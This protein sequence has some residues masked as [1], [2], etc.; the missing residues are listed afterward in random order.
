MMSYF[1]GKKVRITL[2]DQQANTH[3]GVVVEQDG[4]DRVMIDCETCGN[5]VGDAEVPKLHEVTDIK[6][7]QRLGLGI[8]TKPIT[9]D[10]CAGYDDFG[11][12]AVS[13][14]DGN[15]ITST[16]VANLLG[17][18]CRICLRGWE[19]TGPGLRDQFEWGFID[20]YV[21]ES[22]YTRYA[23]LEERSAV[24]LSLI[25]ARYR[26]RG[27]VEIENGYW[28]KVYESSKKPW[29]R[30]RLMDF[31]VEMT[32]GRRKRVWEI[33]VKPTNKGRLV[34][35]EKLRKLLENEDVTKGFSEERVYVHAWSDLKLVEYLKHIASCMRSEV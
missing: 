8:I 24:Y 17:R 18:T 16:H 28:P 20:D 9:E 15:S 26:F 6:Q 13:W 34:W 11:Q 7:M 23:A 27:I 1:V 31:D 22:C 10:G 30:P 3:T 19:P 14:R 5:M 25:E 2:R 21:H 29:Y 12:F 33:E 35:S 32:V 4:F